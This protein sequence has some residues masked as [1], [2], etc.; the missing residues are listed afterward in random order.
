MKLS[1]GFVVASWAVQKSIL[2]AGRNNDGIEIWITNFLCFS[3]E[4]PNYNHFFAFSHLIPKLGNQFNV[5][6]LLVLRS[7]ILAQCNEGGEE[8]LALIFRLQSLM[9]I[10]SEEATVFEHATIAV[11]L[12][13]EKHS[14]LTKSPKVSSASARC[15]TRF[16]QQ[17][18]ETHWNVCRRLKNEERKLNYPRSL[19]DLLQWNFSASL[20]LTFWW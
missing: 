11:H 3:Y 14:M 5:Q 2:W 1:A 19:S 8:F 20:A 9:K 10:F 4:I 6:L 18:R 12:T 13:K 17:R 16:S 7:L 15:C